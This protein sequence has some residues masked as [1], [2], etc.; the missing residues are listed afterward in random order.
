MIIGTP[1]GFAGLLEASQ[2]GDGKPAMNQQNDNNRQPQNQQ[3]NPQQTV[4]GQQNQQGDANRGDRSGE[5]IDT[6]GDG[7]TR[8]PNDTRPTDNGGR[9]DP[10]QR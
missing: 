5:R 9:G 4:P 6:D 2:G 3:Q 8:D 1:G 7:R 10:V